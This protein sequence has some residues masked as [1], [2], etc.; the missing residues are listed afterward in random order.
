[1]PDQ[2]RNIIK[3][4]GLTKRYP[5]A[6]KPAIDNLSLTVKEGE[7]FGLLGPNGAGKTTTISILCGLVKATR[8]QINIRG[9]EIK[10]AARK[11]KGLMGVVPQ[12]IAL[13]PTLTIRENL[14][15]FGRLYGLSDMV[16]KDRIND[17][18]KIAGLERETNQK[19]AT[20]S[21]GIQRRAN[22]IAAI[23]HKPKIL[24]LDEPTVGIDVQSRK[25]LLDYFVRLNQEGTTIIYTSHYMEE[26][27]RIC[28]R[29]AIL[30]RGHVVIEGRA[31]DL[32]DNDPEANN[33]EG[34]FLNITGNRSGGWAEG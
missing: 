12:E 9:M 22:L 27:E 3:I 32:V 25:V 17:Y 10:Y 7:I 18:I 8:G 2:D 11:I 13:Y 33:L 1:M 19:T 28:S 23:L 21:G 30:N 5:R 14:L 20:C 15:F 26:A 31:K 24:F 16:L 6:K 29:V 4:T 34:L